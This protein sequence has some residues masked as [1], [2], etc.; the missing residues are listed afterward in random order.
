MV[1]SLNLDNPLAPTFYLLSILGHVEHVLLIRTHLNCFHFQKRLKC[2]ECVKRKPQII[3]ITEE[4]EWLWHEIHE[5]LSKNA[6]KCKCYKCLR[7]GHQTFHKKCSKNTSLKCLSVYNKG[8]TRIWYY[9]TATSTT[10]RS[11]SLF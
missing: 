10:L 7:R 5:N 2:L 8:Y 11:D 4:P 3:L 6:S 1:L 9:L